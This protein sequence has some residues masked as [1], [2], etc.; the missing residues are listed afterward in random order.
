MILTPTLFSPP[1]LQDLLRKPARYKSL[2]QPRASTPSL[3]SWLP[4]QV[5]APG[6]NSW[7]QLLATTLGYNSLPTAPHHD[8]LAARF[9]P[10]T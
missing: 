2:L 5:T 10:W 9:I 8:L 7:L 4:F 3:N 1:N 6:Y